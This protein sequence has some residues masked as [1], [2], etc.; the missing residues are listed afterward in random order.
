[1][2]C[3]QGNLRSS[4][5]PQRALT[6]TS[7]SARKRNR[8]RLERA[9]HAAAGGDEDIALGLIQEVFIGRIDDEKDEIADGIREKINREIRKYELDGK[10]KQARRECVSYYQACNTSRQRTQQRKVQSYEYDIVNFNEGA[11]SIQATQRATDKYGILRSGPKSVYMI[12]AI[13]KWMFNHLRDEWNVEFKS[14]IEEHIH[15]GTQHVI[16][17]IIETMCFFFFVF[18]NHKLFDVVSTVYKT[19]QTEIYLDILLLLDSK[20]IS[21]SKEKTATM[22]LAKFAHFLSE[23]LELIIYFIF[24]IILYTNLS[25]SYTNYTFFSK[26]ITIHSMPVSVDIAKRSFMY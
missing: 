11:P 12:R 4:R 7:K 3:I 2:V 20:T 25:A 13:G 16:V 22:I 14:F 9:V 26:Q 1:M 23:N 24:F 18:I 17:P 10:S 15:K 19:T 21:N 5:I 6:G 8:K